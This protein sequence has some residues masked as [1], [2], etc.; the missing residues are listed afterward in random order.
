MEEQSS[1]EIFNILGF[2]CDDIIIVEGGEEE[3]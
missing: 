2:V 3:T 1:E